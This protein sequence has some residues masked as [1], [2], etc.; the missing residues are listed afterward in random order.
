MTV[1]ELIAHLTTLPPG[2]TILAPCC[3][4]AVIP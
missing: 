4:E 3:T 2:A 1:A